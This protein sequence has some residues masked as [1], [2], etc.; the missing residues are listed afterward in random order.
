MRSSGAWRQK[1]LPRIMPIRFPGNP[2]LCVMLDQV[3]QALCGAP[4]LRPIDDVALRAEPR[5]VEHT[6]RRASFFKSR[7][8]RV[9]MV[10]ARLVFVRHDD[11][12][13]AGRKIIPRVLYPNL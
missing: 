9:G 11:D 8:C 4:G 7:R 2:W 6:D 1:P 13:S 5:E 10:P 12:I 3:L